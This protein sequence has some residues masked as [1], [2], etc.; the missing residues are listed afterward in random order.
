MVAKRNASSKAWK[1]VTEDL[2]WLEEEIGKH[3]DDVSAEVKANRAAFRKSLRG[4]IRAIDDSVDALSNL[5]RDD[6]VRRDLTAIAGDVPAALLA[7]LRTAGQEVRDRVKPQPARP[8]SQQRAKRSSETTST[9]QPP[10]RAAK[11]SS[12][13]K[14]APARTATTAKPGNLPSKRTPR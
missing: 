10:A 14:T 2:A 5:M 8:R 3:V 12:A 13:R 1:Q 11:R 9:T 4:L 6:D 7:S